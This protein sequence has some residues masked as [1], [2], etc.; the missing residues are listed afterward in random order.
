[1]KKIEFSEWL[2][3]SVMCSRSEPRRRSKSNEA[4]AV[5]VQDITHKLR[6]PH[7]SA[8][9]FDGVVKVAGKLPKLEEIK[10]WI[11]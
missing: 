6:S 4:E 1:M 10:G 2:E 3:Q 5:K 9:S 8:F 7:N 11:K